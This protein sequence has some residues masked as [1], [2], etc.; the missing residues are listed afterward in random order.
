MICLT[1]T[2]YIEKDFIDFIIKLIS[3]YKSKLGFKILSQLENEEE[4]ELNKILYKL[5]DILFDLDIDNS[6]ENDI[7]EE[8]YENND[9]EF[10]ISDD[11][12]LE[13]NKEL[14][15]NESKI[16]MQKKIKQINE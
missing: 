1:N 13:E 2:L 16:S 14:I 15:I 8:E 4:L 5:F 3:K 7:L 6:E 10:E 9:I 11:I 12:D